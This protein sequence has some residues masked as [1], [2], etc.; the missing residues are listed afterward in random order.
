ML[1]GLFLIES[2]GVRIVNWYIENNISY[3]CLV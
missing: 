3:G 2:Q 1:D